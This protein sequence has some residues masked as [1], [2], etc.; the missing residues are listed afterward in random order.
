MKVDRRWLWAGGILTIAGGGALALGVPLATL[1]TLAAV[2]ACPAA[3]Y[4]G[5]GMMGRMQGG[6]ETGGGARALDGRGAETHTP[7]AL[8]ASTGT[9]APSRAPTLEAPR[10]NDDPVM[11]LKRRLAAGEMTLE[12]YDRLLAVIARAGPGRNASPTGQ[13]AS[14]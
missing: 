6:A 1:I 2:L 13:G 3:M 7:V 5:M 4:F 9:G 14:R 8:P 11:I 10:V 12:E